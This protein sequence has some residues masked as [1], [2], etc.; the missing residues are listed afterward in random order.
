MLRNKGSILHG[1]LK[2]LIFLHPND[3]FVK[4]FYVHKIDKYQ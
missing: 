4:E 2:K 1:P 3:R